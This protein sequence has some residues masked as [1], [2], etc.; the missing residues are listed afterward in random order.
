MQVALGG[1]WVSYQIDDLKMHF[2]RQ[3]DQPKGISNSRIGPEEGKHRKGENGHNASGSDRQ[4][5]PSPAPSR[6]TLV[7]ALDATKRP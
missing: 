4:A 1:A 6:D 2:V 5:H 7:V 3:I